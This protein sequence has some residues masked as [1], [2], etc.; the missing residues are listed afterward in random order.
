M[1][2]ILFWFFIFI[3]IFLTVQEFGWALFIFGISNFIIM[4]IIVNIEED[5]RQSKMAEKREGE[6][7]C[8]FA[9]SFEFRKLDTKIIR[10]CT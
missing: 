1:Y 4:T 5:K 10:C 3:I 6:S 8:T 7:I 2:C 9:R